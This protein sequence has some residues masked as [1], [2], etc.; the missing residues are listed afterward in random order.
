MVFF[1]PHAIRLAFV[2]IPCVIVVMPV[3]VVVAIIG[4]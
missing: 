3:V 2:V 4:S 1:H